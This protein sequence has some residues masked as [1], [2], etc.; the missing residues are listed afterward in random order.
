MK[1]LVS[2]LFLLAIGS[3]LQSQSYSLSG[4]KSQ[5]DLLF[6][7]LD[8]TKI[9]TGFLWDTAVNLVEKED[10]NGTALTDSNYVSVSVMGD[11][12]YTINSASV[13]AD[14]IGVQAALSRIQ[15][16]SFFS[17]Q[18]V[19]FLFQPYNYIVEDALTDNLI[20]YA[21]DR[22]SDSYI[23][24]IWQ[25]PYAEDVLFGYAIGGET[26]VFTNTTFTIT[27]ID[28]LSVLSFQSIM[29]DPGDG[30]GFR[31]VSM[32]GTVV[33]NY[34]STGYQETKLKVICGG[35][36]YVSHGTV[37]VVPLPQNNISGPGSSSLIY[38]EDFTYD[39]LGTQF[40]ARVSYNLPLCF[41]N[42]LIVSERFD[43]WR[44]PIIKDEKPPVHEYSGFYSLFDFTDEC[45]FSSLYNIFYIDWYNYDADIRI[46]AELLKQIIHWVNE[47]K[48][49]GNKN[50]VL[51]QSMGGLIARY[52][53]CEMEVAGDAHDTKLFISHDVPH[54]G[55][56][57]SPGLMF[58]YRDI[59]DVYDNLLVAGIYYFSGQWPLFTELTG[60]GDHRSVRQM[61]SNYVNSS[62]NYN[63]VAF[64]Q[65]QE[66]LNE[67]GF[68][69]GDAGSPLENVAIVNGGAPG[70]VSA[71]YSPGDHMLDIHL[72][73]SS[74]F[75]LGAIVSLMYSYSNNTKCALIPG[76][77][78]LRYDL[79]AFPFLSNGALVHRM[80]ISYTKKF[81]WCLNK[82]FVI[83]DISHYAPPSGVAFDNVSA[84]SYN[85]DADSVRRKVFDTIP[86]LLP[87]QNLSF[88]IT[89]HL[90][91]IPTASAFASTDYY[92]DF[93]TSHPRPILDT[94]FTSYIMPDTATVHTSFYAGIGHWLDTI[95]SMDIDG[96]LV[97]QD[98]SIYSMPSEYSSSFSWSTS[99]Y[100]NAYMNPVTGVLH[101]NGDNGYGLIDIIAT[102]D[103]ITH[104]I[105]K[106]KTVLLGAPR[107][108][109]TSSHAGTM[110][111]LKAE[112]LDE[113]VEE[114]L[115][116][117][118]LVDSLLVNWHI[119][120]DGVIDSTSYNNRDSILLNIPDSVRRFTATL[121]VSLCGRRDE[122]FEVIKEKRSY[123]W[124]IVDIIRFED[125]TVYLRGGHDWLTDNDDP[126]YFKLKLN[127][128]EG[129]VDWPAKLK[130]TAGNTILRTT[131]DLEI[132][133]DYVIWDLFTEPAVVSLINLAYRSGQTK[134]LIIEI[135]KDTEETEAN[136]VQTIVIPIHPRVPPIPLF[137]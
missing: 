119:S 88:D 100:S 62:W 126:P 24:G 86:A 70:S 1:R 67:M 32:G 44:L 31:T 10:Y 131:G 98:G 122:V 110:Y 69:K 114:F 130:A 54:K 97:T 79:E 35:H 63:N 46:N 93:R 68:P 134:E 55:A 14:T 135:F 121:K 89:K 106:R 85:I 111:T 4:I 34:A 64:N 127:Q 101:F 84:S 48:T 109:I 5:L 50:V 108:A 128:D 61:L 91:F 25:N 22:V 112:C 36:E 33:A 7:D 76:K 73:S 28:S 3:P 103:S 90:S 129:T 104:V 21:N 115:S 41:D 40:K 133:D 12:L 124:N 81:L 71:W 9:P 43:P 49:S 20:V 65:F 132:V 118:G 18:M 123:R 107:M 116:K 39:T 82:N 27:N 16:N 125:E 77:T 47:N 105:T 11:M 30:G 8:K 29:F 99:S 17:Q 58:A 59:I 42:P 38:W 60:I 95:E 13:G 52:A 117:T 53:L 6:S 66:T 87:N 15:R 19:G 102:K 2:L 37:N 96:P 83:K 78:T 113:G 56:N 74:D 72:T 120:I 45:P 75:L 136:L 92:R 80:R 57:I 137:P 94:P 26:S 51:G 23:S